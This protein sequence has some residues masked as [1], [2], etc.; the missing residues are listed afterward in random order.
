MVQVYAR[1][2]GLP[3][4]DPLAPALSSG[5]GPALPGLLL[6]TSARVSPGE[7]QHERQLIYI[8]IPC[9]SS[10]SAVGVHAGL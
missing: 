3:H 10:R 6:L 5:V 1:L 9:A 2:P 4:C 7:E 8:K